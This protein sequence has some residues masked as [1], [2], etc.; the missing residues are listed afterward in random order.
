MVPSD[1]VAA[2]VIGIFSLK[3]L[4][5]GIYRCLGANARLVIIFQWWAFFYFGRIYGLGGVFFPIPPIPATAQCVFELFNKLLC[6]GGFA[7]PHPI[8]QSTP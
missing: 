4:G 8:P 3:S 2:A 1:F 7:S 5:H 6:A